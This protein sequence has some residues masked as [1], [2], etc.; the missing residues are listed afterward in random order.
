MPPYTVGWGLGRRLCPFP[1][2]RLN[3]LAENEFRCILGDICDLE[4]Q[5]TERPGERERERE[6][7]RD[8]DTLNSHYIGAWCNSSPYIGQQT[9]YWATTVNRTHPQADI[10]GQGG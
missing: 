1:E 10:H 8:H 6:R 5:E 4:L 2:K 3:F 9:I 7:E